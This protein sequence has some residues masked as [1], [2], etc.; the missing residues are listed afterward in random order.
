MKLNLQEVR[1]PS[2]KPYLQFPL[3]SRFFGLTK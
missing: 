1:V 2:P 3:Y